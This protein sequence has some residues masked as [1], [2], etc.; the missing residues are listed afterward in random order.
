[1]SL[2]ISKERRELLRALSF[3]AEAELVYDPDLPGELRELFMGLQIAR[4][5]QARDL[6]RKLPRLYADHGP[7]MIRCLLELSYLMH[8][9]S[10]L[11]DIFRDVLGGLHKDLMDKP[12]WRRPIR[13]EVCRFAQSPYTVTRELVDLLLGVLARIPGE[14][15]GLM[16]NPAVS[17]E[18]RLR[19]AEEVVRRGDRENYPAV[20][21]L[22]K[23]HVRG[24]TEEYLTR[25]KPASEVLAG[26]G[27]R[28]LELAVAA[29]EAGE[30]GH[31]GPY[32]IAS[33]RGH[34]LRWLEEQEMRP[35]RRWVNVL[36]QAW[37][38]Q[39]SASARD[40][41]LGILLDEWCMVPEI[42]ALVRAKLK[43]KVAEN[44]HYLASASDGMRTRVEE[45]AGTDAPPRNL[46]PLILGHLEGKDTGWEEFAN[47]MPENKVTG[48][49]LGQ[50]MARV[51][52]EGQD[53]LLRW[54]RMVNNPRILAG[55]YNKLLIPS[56]FFQLAPR[57]QRGVLQHPRV[58]GHVQSGRLGVLLES[59]QISRLDEDV[60]A[61][62]EGLY[63]QL[64]GPGARKS[65][66]VRELK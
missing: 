61:A 21:E 45:F 25:L 32:V 28:G 41:T 24:G 30:L 23:Q 12:L 65:G 9:K 52:P 19:A 50:A 1:M 4:G 43:Q 17:F 46:L 59:T 42:A 51:D 2:N 44:P 58:A 47:G 35:N 13:E 7:P 14:T 5:E 26:T 36:L 64:R 63:R 39:G 6:A 40:L 56:R 37:S 60:R 33:F 10:A 20:L 22:V 54:L 34:L 27:R 29:Y 8:L 38:W 57:T 16:R 66:R 31:H 15:A 49:A 3:D 62:M 11:A 48:W 18:D 53:K 55:F